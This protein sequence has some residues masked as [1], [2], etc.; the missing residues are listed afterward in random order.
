[1]Q[2]CTEDFPEPLMPSLTDQVQVNIAKGWQESIGVIR[3]HGGAVVACLHPVVGNV[4]SFQRCHPDSVHLVRGGK[5][6]LL[7]AEQEC[8]VIGKRP[9]RT[10]GDNARAIGGDVTVTTQH[11]VRKGELTAA[12]WSKNGVI[13][14]P[15]RGCGVGHGECS[16]LRGARYVACGGIVAAEEAVKGGKGNREPRRPIARLVHGLVQGLVDFERAQYRSEYIVD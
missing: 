11:I 15:G 8:D 13:Y 9:A 4:L 1:M 16:I 12:N 10:Q 6:R 7:G 14:N 5:G 3:D 2:V